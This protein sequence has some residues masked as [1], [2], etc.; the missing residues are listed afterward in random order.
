[1]IKEKSIDTRSR[2]VGLQTAN[3]PA[4]KPRLGKVYR[5][6][7]NYEPSAVPVTQDKIN[8]TAPEMDG[9]RSAVA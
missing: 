1:V 4:G 6:I 8:E 2:L 5:L 3:T 7:L 9:V